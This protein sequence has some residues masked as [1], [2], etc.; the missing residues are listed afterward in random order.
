VKPQD[1]FRALAADLRKEAQRQSE[2]RRDKAAGVLV[3]A[4]GLGMLARKLGG[5]RG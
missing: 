5:T 3:A 1:M 4:A 2:I